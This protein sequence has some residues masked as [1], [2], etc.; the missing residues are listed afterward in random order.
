MTKASKLFLVCA[1]IL[2]LRGAV[3]AQSS[4]L[5]VPS[6]DVVAT[7]QVYVEMDFI[8]NY[9]WQRDDAR[10]ANYLPRAVVGVGKNVEVGANVSYTHVPGGGE[11]IELQP[12]AKWQFYSNKEKGVAASVGCIWFI[13]VTRRTDTDTFG[14]CYSVA[15]KQFSGKYGPRLTG[16]AYTLIGASKD[17]GTK[18]GAVVAWEQPLTKRLSFIV[19]WQSG[20]NRLG[21]LSPGLNLN[22]PHNASLSGGYAIANRGH[23][24]NGL[25]VY[26]G[27]QF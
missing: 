6:T 18:T 24:N 7:K 11:P 4:L 12:N 1:A 22:L 13:P 9:A 5:N 27:L 14:Q 21:Y 26:Y 10:F 25:F 15:S 17:Q 16:G 19:D 2:F 3:V 8:T 23:Q 20:Y